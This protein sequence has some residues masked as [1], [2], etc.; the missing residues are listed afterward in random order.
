MLRRI[1]CLAIV[2]A[3]AGG[4]MPLTGE[5]IAALPQV[6]RPNY[7]AFTDQR[8]YVVED[9]S[10]IHIFRRGPEG[11]VFERTFG[12]EGEGPG[13]FG[14]IHQIR[15]LAGHLEIPTEGKF[16]RYT[17][18]GKLIDEVKLPFRVFKNW[19]FRVGGNYVAKDWRFDNKETVA[20]ISLYDKDLKRIREL[21]THTDA[22][23]VSKI[24]L[25]AEHYSARVF[26]EKIFLVESGKETIV[27]VHDRDGALEKEVRLPLPPV[28]VTSALREAII[29]PIREQPD[30]K[31]RWTA[32]EPRI[33]FPDHTPGLDYFDVVDGKFITRTYQYRED[34]VEF[35]IFDLQGRELK[36]LFL[37]HTGRLANG[38]TFC[39][40]QGRYY[41][42]RENLDEETWELH[43]EK[44]W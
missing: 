12:E 2:L 38:R 7:L 5:K 1:F 40:F 42:L 33:A 44:A 10:K 4:V 26:G 21:G 41:H 25:V 36:R 24:N 16:A 3:A 9:S 31:S 22:G 14:Y 8:I 19:I 13:E 34:S 27:R 6:M 39:F 15:P 43:A 37:P 18:D 35:V 28:K 23:G 11:V 17:L 32:F 20:T 30:M 29:R